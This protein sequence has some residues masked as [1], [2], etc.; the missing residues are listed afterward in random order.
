MDSFVVRS[1]YERKSKDSIYVTEREREM[2]I[3][4]IQK[5]YSLFSSLLLSLSLTQKHNFFF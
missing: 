5:K 1:K 2:I 3:K 4:E